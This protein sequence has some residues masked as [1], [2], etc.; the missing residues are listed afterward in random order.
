M[1]RKNLYRDFPILTSLPPHARMSMKARI[2]ADRRC[3]YQAT[4][5]ASYPQASQPSRGVRENSSILLKSG[6]ASSIL[7]YSSVGFSEC[8]ARSAKITE[9]LLSSGAGGGICRSEE[10]TS[11]LQSREN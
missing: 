8:W 11:E 5:T 2:R 3:Q 10:H 9:D 4:F 6:Y 7:S 1:S